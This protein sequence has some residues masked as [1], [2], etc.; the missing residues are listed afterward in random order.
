MYLAKLSDFREKIREE[1]SLCTYSVLEEDYGVN[2]WYLWN[3]INDDSYE[4]PEH[5]QTVLRIQIYKPAPVCDVHGIVHCYDCE[6]ET[7]KP[8]KTNGKS[9]PHRTPPVRV[10]ECSNEE[11]AAIKRLTPA[12][13]KRRMLGG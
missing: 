9:R 7:V 1:K 3:I 4:P 5:I 13:R 8:V 12:E 2:R 6:K 11:W 10:G